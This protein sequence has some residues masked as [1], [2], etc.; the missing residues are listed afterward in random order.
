[1]KPLVCVAV[2]VQ[3]LASSTYA[4]A[5]EQ[6]TFAGWLSEH[7]SLQQV[8]KDKR[9]V[10]KPAY[11]SLSYPKS[12][13]SQQEASIAA[14][15]DIVKSDSLEIGPALA[16]VKSTSS[17][18]PQDL[19]EAGVDATWIARVGTPMA[20]PD[21]PDTTPPCFLIA[22]GELKYKRDGV[23][24][25]SGLAAALRW[26]FTAVPRKWK[27][28]PY[29]IFPL[30]TEQMRFKWEPRVGFEYDNAISA[31]APSVDG[32][33]VRTYEELGLYLYPL[34]GLIKD[35]LVLSA[36]WAHRYDLATP[37]AVAG[38][39]HYLRTY[40]ALLYFDSSRRVAVGVDRVSGQDPSAGVREQRLSR[41]SLKWRL[42]PK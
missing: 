12:S 6:K 26:A 4:V 11:L 18:K 17:D 21:I 20:I 9:S 25:T 8:I 30:W 37:A 36:T 13:A 2:A 39:N 10:D 14:V 31:K 28:T 5:D 42:K 7:L 32:T 40:S 41:V 22:E 23:A 38:D 35:K 34:G 3:T 19:L 16:Y 24:D 29:Y 1:M 15:L 27:W 33:T